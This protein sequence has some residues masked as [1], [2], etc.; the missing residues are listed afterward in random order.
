LIAGIQD[1]AVTIEVEKRATQIDNP[2]IAR[3]QESTFMSVA[4]D[5]RSAYCA[6]TDS[7]IER[8]EPSGSHTTPLEQNAAGIP[9]AA[10][11]SEGLV[12]AS[13]FKFGSALPRL[14]SARFTPLVLSVVSCIQTAC[15][16]ILLR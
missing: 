2:K 7:N 8:S 11:D 10:V 16:P 12:S 15:Q 6:L 13:N 14:W 4:S 3:A 9:T 1:L 5:Y